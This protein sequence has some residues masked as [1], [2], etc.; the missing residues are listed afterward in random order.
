[1]AQAWPLSSVGSHGSFFAA[2]QPLAV[3]QTSYRFNQKQ[4]SPSCRGSRRADPSAAAMI[5]YHRTTQGNLDDHV[6]FY[7]L[8]I[9][10]HATQ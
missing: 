2:F 1:M 7:V 8:P 9:R 3:A 4:E 6:K 10:V 5:C